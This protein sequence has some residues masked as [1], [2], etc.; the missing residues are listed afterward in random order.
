[1]AFYEG[2]TSCNVVLEKE[3]LLED[4][5]DY[6]NDWKRLFIKKM[7]E[8]N[9]VLEKDTPNKIIINKEWKKSLVITHKIKEKDLWI[10]YKIKYHKIAKLLLSFIY[11]LMFIIFL[12]VLLSLLYLKFYSPLE[13]YYDFIF[14]IYIFMAI[15]I[16][17]LANLTTTMIISYGYNYINKRRHEDIIVDIRTCAKEAMKDIKKDIIT[18]VLKVKKRG[19]NY[20]PSCGKKVDQKWNF[21]PYC[22]I[23]L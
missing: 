13:D 10:Y 2:T 17:I 4:I 18:K 14:Y 3:I 12:G 16:Y 8:N 11:I 21:C 20:C 15:F 1:M 5:G 9:Y 6:Y 7:V 23:E 19:A 22:K